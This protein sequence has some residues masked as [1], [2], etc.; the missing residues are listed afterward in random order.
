L[1]RTDA[2]VKYGENYQSILTNIR[3][4]ISESDVNYDEVIRLLNELV[5]IKNPN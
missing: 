1:C 3:E 5:K 4:F 2:I